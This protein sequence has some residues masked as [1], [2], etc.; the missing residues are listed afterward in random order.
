MK[1]HFIKELYVFLGT[2][3]ILFS[4]CL[5]LMRKQVFKMK[6]IFISVISLIS[7]GGVYR[8]H[9]L[10]FLF[11]VFVYKHW[12]LWVSVWQYGNYLQMRL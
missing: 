5:D 3:L 8:H 7:A 12:S 11:I 2:F 6:K 4:G 10:F 9:L 1:I